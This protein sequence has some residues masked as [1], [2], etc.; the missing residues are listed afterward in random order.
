MGGEG[1]P[2]GFEQEIEMWQHKQGVYVQPKIGPGE[3]DIQT[4]L[5]FW[6]TYR[7]PNFSHTTRSS[8][9]QQKKRTCWIVNFAIPADDR[10]K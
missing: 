2:L 3:W 4:S 9:S 10:V 1:D 8:N 6:E 7:S 5:G